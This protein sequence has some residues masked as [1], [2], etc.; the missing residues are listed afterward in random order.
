MLAIYGASGTGKTHLARGLVQSWQERG[1]DETD[2]ADCAQYLPAADFRHVFLDA[3]KRDAV[4]DFRRVSAASGC[5]PST[6]STASRATRTFS[7][8][9]ATRSTRW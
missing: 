6:T 5:S 4:S 8:N 3:I 9:C 1:S 7:K 2:S